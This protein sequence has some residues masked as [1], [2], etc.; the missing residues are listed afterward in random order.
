MAT[1]NC[2]EK[3][4]RDLKGNLKQQVPP[5]V[6][7][8][9]GIDVLMD[10]IQKLMQHDLIT[11]VVLT[12]NGPYGAVLPPLGSHPGIVSLRSLKRMLV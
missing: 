9:V 8:V 4:W 6:N 7:L 10:E 5:V 3:Y 11:A 2:L 12:L 1:N